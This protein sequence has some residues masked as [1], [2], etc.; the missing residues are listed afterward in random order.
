[1]TRFVL[2]AALFLAAVPAFAQSGATQ[3]PP[4]PNASSQGPTSANS[5]PAGAL[6]ANPSSASNPC[7]SAGV[8]S[9]VTQPGAVVLTPS[10]PAAGAGDTTIP[11]PVR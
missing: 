2:A 11:T 1:M 4:S 10:V 8:G 3:S 9:T 5:V 7:P 6:T